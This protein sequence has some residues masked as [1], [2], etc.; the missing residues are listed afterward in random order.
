MRAITKIHHLT[1]KAHNL[2]ISGT[3]LKTMSTKKILFSLVF[4]SLTHLLLVIVTDQIPDLMRFWF[5]DTSNTFNG[6]CILNMI[7][8]CSWNNRFSHSCICSY[9]FS[10]FINSLKENIKS[11]LLK[12]LSDTTECFGENR[13]LLYMPTDLDR[14]ISRKN[15]KELL[16]NEG[17]YF[18]IGFQ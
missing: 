9:V 11:L 6:L 15:D 12:F 5:D 10:G 3:I 14:F 1:H 2:Q 7:S 13:K 16:N 8:N 17:L 18:R 4:L